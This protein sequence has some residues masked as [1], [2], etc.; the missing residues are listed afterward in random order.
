MPNN[1]A[2]TITL[3]VTVIVLF[4]FLFGF[5]VKYPDIVSGDINISSE[6]PPLQLVAEQSGRLRINNVTSQDK[7]QSGQLLAWIDNPAHP[8]LIDKLTQ[9]RDSLVFPVTFAK[10]VY[11]DL[12][13]NLNLG[14]L[15]MPYPSFLSAIKQLADYQESHL[16]DR[17]GSS[18]KKF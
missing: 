7:I 12:P 5:I 15:S 11:S 3:I 17:Q 9:I 8:K 4:L 6:Q 1:F 14:D 18:L 2:K 16:Y 10:S 13:K